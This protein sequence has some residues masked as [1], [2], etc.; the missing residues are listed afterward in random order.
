MF[1][2]FLDPDDPDLPEPIR[3][4]I[5][6]HQAYHERVEMQ[7]NMTSHDIHLL[8]QK[9]VGLGPD[10]AVLFRA[11]LVAMIEETGR[12]PYHIGIVVM[13][14]DKQHGICPACGIQHDEEL[15]DII[16]KEREAMK[17]AAEEEDE[18]IELKLDRESVL[19]AN[20]QI[21]NP[22]DSKRHW[23]TFISNLP[24]EIADALPLY[25]LNL[26]PGEWP[27]VLCKCGTKYV[28][29]EDRALRPPGVEGC[30]TCQQKEKFG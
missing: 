8:F 3:R 2:H 5:H 11:F 1:E 20:G 30:S 10:E 17:K 13:E 25:N 14:S 9:I 28:S 24:E 16:V 22:N 27:N 23:A 19:L 12:I 21:I 7:M 26:I 29:I 18:P 6:Q 4:A 15:A